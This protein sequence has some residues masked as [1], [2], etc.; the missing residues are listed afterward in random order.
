MVTSKIY[1]QLSQFQKGDNYIFKK[2]LY[3]SIQEIIVEPP[4]RAIKVHIGV[5]GWL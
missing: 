3:S 4:N 5:S 1:A 2:L